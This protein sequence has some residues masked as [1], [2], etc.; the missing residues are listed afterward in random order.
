MFTSVLKAYNDLNYFIKPHPGVA[1][2]VE[3]VT[4]EGKVLSLGGGMPHTDILF[5]LSLK[6]YFT[7]KSIF[8]IGNSFGYSC[9]VLSKIFPDA[10]I[11]AIDAEIEGDNNCEGSRITREI[12]AKH[13]PKVQLTKGFS[14]QD[15]SKAMREKKYDLMFIDGMH[16]NDQLI[17]DFTGC[18]MFAAEQCVVYMHDVD[19]FNMQKGI[20]SLKNNFQNYQF[21][22]VPISA[23]GSKCAVRNMPQVSEWLNTLNTNNNIQISSRKR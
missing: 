19:F 20:Q 10:T 7:P 22:D 21:F 9:F 23:V 8:I 16:T 13:F 5:F 11:D 18:D 1:F 12:A 2:A 3:C 17:K 4:K 15:L 6:E 14:P